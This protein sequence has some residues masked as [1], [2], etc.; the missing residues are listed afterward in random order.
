MMPGI[1]YVAARKAEQ[2]DDNISD[3]ACIATIK[4]PNSKGVNYHV[5]RK[6]LANYL[7]EHLALRNGE[8][9]FDE[10]GQEAVSAL[11]A[12]GITVG[13]VRQWLYKYTGDYIRKSFILCPPNKHQ[14]QFL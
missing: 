5:H 12:T 14:R 3:P 1:N 4:C 7:N 9:R 11:L 13:T 10:E 2:I 8:W 6:S